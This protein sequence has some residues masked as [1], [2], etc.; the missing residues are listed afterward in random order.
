MTLHSM[1][2]V[3]QMVDELFFGKSFDVKPPCVIYTEKEDSLTEKKVF[4]Q[5]ALAGFREEDVKVYYENNVLYVSGN[6]SSNESVALKFKNN[7][8]HE[9]PVNRT[10]DLSKSEV[11]FQNGLLTISIPVSTEKV[12]KK[13]LF[14]N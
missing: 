1:M 8:H 4:I 2:T 7:F 5:Y 13:L 3:Q 14:G 11:S 9:I 10:L 6:N 12:S